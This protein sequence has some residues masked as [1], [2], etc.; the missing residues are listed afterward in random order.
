MQYC[1]VGYRN[2]SLASCLPVAENYSG[3]AQ[4]SCDS[5]ALVDFVSLSFKHL[6]LQTRKNARKC[7]AVKPM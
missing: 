1:W 6:G 7:T 5:I 3:I 2:D 4:F